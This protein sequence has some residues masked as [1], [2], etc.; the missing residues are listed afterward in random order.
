MVELVWFVR[1][2]ELLHYIQPH[3]GAVAAVEPY[4]LVSP[5]RAEQEDGEEEVQARTPAQALKW[6]LTLMA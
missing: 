3:I 1:F 6:E 5:E 2:P 4:L